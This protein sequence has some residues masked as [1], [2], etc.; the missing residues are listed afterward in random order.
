MVSKIKVNSIKQYHIKD[1]RVVSETTLTTA[2]MLHLMYLHSS[3]VSWKSPL[4]KEI[5]FLFF[6]A[7]RKKR[8]FE[9]VGRKESSWI[10]VTLWEERLMHYCLFKL[11][12]TYEKI[13]YSSFK[14]YIFLPLSFYIDR[15]GI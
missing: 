8:I 15:K 10:V 6:L 3:I 12:S 11:N 7:T 9:K 1:N 4:L 5:K 2:I 14:K 13:I